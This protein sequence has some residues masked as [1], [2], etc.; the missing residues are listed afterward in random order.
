MITSFCG[1]I[2]M[3]GILLFNYAVTFGLSGPTCAIIQLQT[4]LVSLMQIT[5]EGKYPKINEMVGMAVC[6]VGGVVIGADWC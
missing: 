5:V 6:M 2:Y 3:V 4:V 1:L